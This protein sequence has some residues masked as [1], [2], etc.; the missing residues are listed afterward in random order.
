MEFIKPYLVNRPDF[1]VHQNE[2]FADK[3]NLSLIEFG[4]LSGLPFGSGSLNGQ[5][6]RT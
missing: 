5:A 4:A 3:L 6:F 1:A 2:G